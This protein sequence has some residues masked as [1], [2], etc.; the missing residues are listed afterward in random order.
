MGQSYARILIT[1]LMLLYSVYASLF[2]YMDEYHQVKTT[3][4]L[5][6]GNISHKLCFPYRKPQTIRDKCPLNKF[7]YAKTPNHIKWYC[8]LHFYI[9]P[10]IIII[11]KS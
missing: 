10:L 4:N 8:V 1:C 11:I 2:S 7:V 6:K 5:K 3:Y 9:K